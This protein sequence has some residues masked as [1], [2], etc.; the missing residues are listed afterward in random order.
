MGYDRCDSFPFDFEPNGFPF[1]S[2]WK[3]KLSPQSFPIPFERKLN[4]SFQCSG[5]ANRRTAVRET[6]VS[7]HHG[8]QLRALKPP[9]HQGTMGFKRGP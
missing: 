7:L 8:A 1:G 3:G 9:V 2:K 5:L 6:A 4:T